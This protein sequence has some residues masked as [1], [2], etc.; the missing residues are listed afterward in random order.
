MS[1]TSKWKWQCKGRK[2]L[3]K[4]MLFLFF[5]YEMLL[6]VCKNSSKAML[7]HMVVCL[8]A[9]ETAGLRPRWKN[10]LRKAPSIDLR[11]TS[12][13]PPWH[14]ALTSEGVGFNLAF[15][16]LG[17][18]LHSATCLALDSA[19][20]RPYKHVGRMSSEGAPKEVGDSML[21]SRLGD[22]GSEPAMR[23]LGPRI[24]TIW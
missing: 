14:L 23:R 7:Q 15:T 5:L 3:K 9:W 1:A 18:C 10:H 11:V 13:R 2:N 24:C 6:F 4:E 16:L 8:P 19:L 17:V 12:E 20:I 22:C 21:P